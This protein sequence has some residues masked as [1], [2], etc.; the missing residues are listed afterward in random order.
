MSGLFKGVASN[1]IV[2]IDLALKI[3]IDLQGKYELGGR[4]VESKFTIMVNNKQIEFTWNQQNETWKG[5]NTTYKRFQVCQNCTLPIIVGI[6]GATRSGKG[7]LAQQLKEKFGAPDVLCLDDAFISHRRIKDV[8][9]N[10]ECPQALD[11]QLFIGQLRILKAQLTTQCNQCRTGNHGDQNQQKNQALP[12]QRSVGIIEGF[13][14]FAHAD[15]L[16][17]LELKIFLNIPKEVCHQRRMTTKRVSEEYFE[18]ILWPSYLKYNGHVLALIGAYE[19]LP[20][21]YSLAYWPDDD[22]HELVADVHFIEGTQA[23]A[24]VFQDAACLIT[25]KLPPA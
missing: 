24:K 13:L 7:E 17:E 9:S 22:L 15:V 10:W 1:N 4:Q 19:C 3:W 20:E 11:W 21:F 18:K 6:S 2:S 25:D 23:K 16:R 12:K 8:A 14:L 5:N